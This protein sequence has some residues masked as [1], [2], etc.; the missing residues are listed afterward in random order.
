MK[1]QG[2]LTN[3]TLDLHSRHPI[4]SFELD[5]SPEDIERYMDKPLDVEITRHTER[6]SLNANAYFH[7]LAGKIADAI[8]TS[9]AESK[10]ILIGR[11]GQQ[12]LISGEP[13]IIKT[14]LP[15]D[16]MMKSEEIHCCPCGTKTE[17]GKVITFYHVYRG[18]HTY[19]TSEMT[20]L[21]DGTV[22]EAKELGIETLTPDEI[23]KMTNSWRA[24]EKHN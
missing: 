19:S 14:N 10:N 6:R 4:A 2:H 7:V 5:A 9:K 22:S 20:I 3:L 18:S 16:R 12:E 17:K 8:N 21:I 13:V 1:A 23:M 11:Y 24:N 15:P